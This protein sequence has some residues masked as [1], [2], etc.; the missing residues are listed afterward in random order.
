VIPLRGCGQV[1]L[2]DV[3]RDISFGDVIYV[4]PND[5]HQFRCDRGSSEPLGFLCIVDAQRDAAVLCSE[6]TD[7]PML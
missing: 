6:E 4:A 3:T 5:A 2:A 7:T 1:R